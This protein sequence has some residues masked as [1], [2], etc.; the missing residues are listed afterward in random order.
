MNTLLFV[1]EPTSTSTWVTVSVMLVGVLT[2]AIVALVNHPMWSS[3]TKRI[4]A[5]VG[6]AVLGVLTVVGNGVLNDMEFNVANAITVILAV[7]GASQAAYG[8]IWKPTGA[9]DAIEQS[10]NTGVPKG[11]A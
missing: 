6:A 11:G 5:Y 8:L 4:I 2:P 3:Q 9:S 7:V 10:V 1:D